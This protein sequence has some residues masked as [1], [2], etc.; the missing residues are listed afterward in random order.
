M[1]KFLFLVLTFFISTA[2]FAQNQKVMTL[3]EA[4]S[5]ALNSNTNLI[6]SQNQLLTSEKRVKNAYGEL[7]P[8]LSASGSWNWRKDEFNS[9]TADSRSYSVGVGGG[10]TLFDGLANYKTIDQSKNDLSSAK[11]SIMKQK[12]DI[13]QNTLDRYY[14]VLNAKEQLNVRIDNVKFNEKLLETIKERNRLGSVAVA[15]VYTQ[16][17]QLGN[18]E[19]ALIRA[20]NEFSYAKVTLLNFL[21][22]EDVLTDYVFSDPRGELLVVDPNFHMN[23]FDEVSVMVDEALK[24][25]LDYKSLK[26]DVLSADYDV[27]IAGTGYLPRLTGSYGWSTGSGSI[28]GLFD[29]NTYTA[30]LTLS[31]PIFSNF[32]TDL[33]VQVAKVG[34]LNQQESLKAKERTIKVEI[35]QGYQDVIAAKK[36]LDVSNKNIKAAS[37]RRKI[38]YERYNLG[39]GT[40]LDVLQADRDYTQ[41]L[42]DD[43]NVEFNFYRAADR[44][45][46]Y[47]GKLDYKKYE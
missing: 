26:L 4:I 7:L 15:D 2:A 11:Y 9:V 34:L 5:I 3:D 20:E 37:E 23:A 41:A 31:I 47:L 39:S 10:V 6:F 32:R 1:Y 33:G 16:Q 36:A 13:V 18:A 12:Q 40:I 45:M 42:S 22:V 44:L 19:L 28:D 24:N 14:S 27:S 30:G 21:G 35:K 17:V 46:N 25:R 43:I 38:S 29:G 8:N